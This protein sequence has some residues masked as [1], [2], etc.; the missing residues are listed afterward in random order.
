MTDALDDRVVRV[1]AAIALLGLVARFAL[2]GTRVAH[3]DEARVA[4]WSLH[5]FE[6]GQFHYRYIIHGPLVQHVARSLFGL[7]GAT[8]F[9]TRVPVALVGG[10]LPLSALWFRHR[11][12]DTEVAALALLLAANPILLYFSRF[13]RS[14]LLVAALCFVA[15][16]AF[17]RWYDGFGVAYFHLGMATL[18]LGFAAKENAIIYVVCWVGA[19]ALLLHHKLYRHEGAASGAAWLRDGVDDA[20]DRVAG[21]DRDRVA[22][23]AGHLVGGVLLLALLVLFFYAP[24]QGVTSGGALAVTQSHPNYA[25]I[26]ETCQTTGLWSSLG[27]GQVGSLVR[28]T[29][30]TIERGLMYWFGGTSETTLTTY[31]ERLGKFLSTSATY[32]GPL[33]ALA[34]AGFVMEH[35]VAG[36]PRHLV[37]GAAYWGFASVLG[38]PL[39]TDIWAAWIIVNALVPLA[40][41]AAVGLGYI[42]DAGRDALAEDDRVSVGAVAVL[43]LLV[44]GQMAAAGVSAVYLNPTSQH[45][46]L[47][48]FAQPEQDMRPAVADTIEISAANGGTDALF[49]GGSDFVDMDQQATRTPACINW[50]RTLPWAWYL[51]ANDVSVTCAN[52]TGQLPA[53]MPPV[54]VAQANCTL[55]RTVD[56]RAKPGAL[57]VDQ[58]LRERIP[59]DYERR[60]FLHRT[61]GGSYFDGMVVYT[62]PDA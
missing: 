38:Y 32:A 35:Y 56:C 60:G 24:R 29:G 53:E 49:Y 4:W 43:L 1:V 31:A 26:V 2:L 54:V 20:V 13:M 48:Q 5:F 8:D 9:A 30:L 45:N 47:V 34:V 62:D 44:G 15:F 46:D 7:F 50:F 27:S 14:S 40:V 36:D 51:S 25:T 22:W 42:V 57:A 10:L 39:G 17:V 21:P 16:A 59:D 19:G 37:L 52:G 58:G 55:D 6:T 12:S 41:P 23:S 11:L 18:A 28:C 61:T 33:L 3:F